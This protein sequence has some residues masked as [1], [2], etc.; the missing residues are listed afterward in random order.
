MK[1]LAKKVGS[2]ALATLMSLSIVSFAA[3]TFSAISKK[4]LIQCLKNIFN[5]KI[6]IILALI[7]RFHDPF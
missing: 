1:N 6:I 4:D 3:C 2:V 5:F 7:F